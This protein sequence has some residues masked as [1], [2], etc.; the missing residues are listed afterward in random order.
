[1]FISS[2]SLFL[3]QDVISKHKQINV[4][5]F[6]FCSA[7]LFL[8]LF[9]TENFHSNCL[10]FDAMILLLLLFYFNTHFQK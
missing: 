8:K 4:K 9:Q 2:P 5:S 7:I 1:M 10:A 3:N 6:C